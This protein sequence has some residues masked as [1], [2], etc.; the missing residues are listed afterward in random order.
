MREK[1]KRPFEKF[2]KDESE[3]KRGERKEKSLKKFPPKK[4]GF[5]P[6]LGGKGK[7]RPEEAEDRNK[8]PRL[9]Q[10]IARA[11]VCSR[12]EADELIATGKVKVNGKVVREM[13]WR[14]H[15]GDKVTYE[16]QLLKGERPIYLLLNKPKGFLSTMSDERGRK[17][18]MQLISSACD[19]RIYPVGRLDR[20]TTGLLLFTNDGDLAK[21]LTHPSSLVKKIYHVYLDKPMT[22][23]HLDAM[24]EGVELEDGFMKPDIVNYVMEQPDGTEFGIQIHSGKNR[25]VRRLFEHFGY[26]VVKLDR[27]LFANLTKKDLPRGKWRMLQEKEVSMLKVVAGKTKKR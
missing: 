27:V 4:G 21:N 7:K 12:R 2:R 22:E 13:G 9:N 26:K 16:G 10:Y 18:V 5:K 8:L 14:V 23:E 3:G 24:N 15:Q 11:G 25:V 1:G 20:E 17:T 19:E 6:K